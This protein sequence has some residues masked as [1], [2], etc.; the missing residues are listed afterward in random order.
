MLRAV[1]LALLSA[2]ARRTA[3]SAARYRREQLSFVA[4]SADAPLRRSSSQ[5]QCLQLTNAAV[6]QLE[7]AAAGRSG[8]RALL[9]LADARQFD[10]CRAYSHCQTQSLRIYSSLESFVVKPLVG[11]LCTPNVLP[12]LLLQKRIGQTKRVSPTVCR[13][14]IRRIYVIGTRHYCETIAGPP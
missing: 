8:W 5:C 1:V 3:S 12:D 10:L 6:S 13:G 9:A 7:L 11:A 2:Q 14:R 4:R